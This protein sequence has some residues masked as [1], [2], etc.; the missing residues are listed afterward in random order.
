MNYDFITIGGATRDISF[1][2]DQGVII[3]NKKD[4]LRQKVL[5]FESGAKI[6][7]DKYY[8]SYGGGAAN[9]AVCLANF[10]LKT[11]CLTVV[12]DDENGHLIVED[13]KKNRVAVNFIS[14]VPKKESG[15]S[16]ILISPSG[17]RIIFAQRGANK[18][19]R[20]SGSDQ[21][22][23]QKTKNIYIA[24]LSGAWSANLKKI[25]SVVK[26]G[27]P[28]IF[29]NPGLTQYAHGL[30][31]MRPFMDKVYVLA[32]NKDE[33]IELVL[34][35]K[36]YGHLSQPFLNKT[37]NLGKI[38]QSFGPQIVLITLG[39]KGV[40]C[41]DGHK[42]YQ[43]PILKE[44][45]RVDTTGIGDVFNSSFAA[46]LNMFNNNINQALSLALKNAAAKVGHLGAHNGLIKL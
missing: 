23:L 1:F 25:F 10:G 26:E 24:S 32:L 18:D 17:E 22:A 35:T 9:A 11:A 40:L 46:G 15:S 6:K 3:N 28:K 7:V 36:G 27:R 5:A 39:A 14:R 34:K 4:I 33:A 45:K 8:Y 42:I 21:S 38:I 29:W 44:H 13:L 16:F 31:G 2:T 20:I 43:R 37:E 19:L 30:E 41:Y 12:G